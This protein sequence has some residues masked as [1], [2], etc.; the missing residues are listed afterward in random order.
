LLRIS[1]ELFLQFGE[2]AIEIKLRRYLINSIAVL[3]D[4]DKSS[5]IKFMYY[6]ELVQQLQMLVEA[7]AG[8]VKLEENKVV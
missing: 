4:Y 8:T 3:M 5:Q 6:Q 7:I 1:R 2:P